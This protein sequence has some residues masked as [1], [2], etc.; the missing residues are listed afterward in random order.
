MHACSFYLASESERG[1]CVRACVHMSLLLE[2]GSLEALACRHQLEYCHPYAR[3]CAVSGRAMQ[4]C[5]RA[6]AA[7]RNV[8]R[9]KAQR[10]ERPET[11]TATGSAQASDHPP[12]KVD[13]GLAPPSS[14]AVSGDHSSVTTSQTPQLAT[15]VRTV[16]VSTRNHFRRT[17]SWR[18]APGLPHARTLV[19]TPSSYKYSKKA[20]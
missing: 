1:T 17:R 11:R 18:L 19:L 5:G 13:R 4:G 16:R 12:A 7:A 6:A 20:G 2:P 10:A 9:V 15:R 8:G 14:P 3:T